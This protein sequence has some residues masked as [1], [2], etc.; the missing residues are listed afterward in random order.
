MRIAVV[1]TGAAIAIGAAAAA[2][3]APLQRAALEPSPLPAPLLGV[4]WNKRTATLARFDPRSLRPDRRRGV[5]IFA[6]CCAYAFSPD[7]SRLVL[8][9]SN[10][11]EP[12]GLNEQ[13]FHAR[14]QLVF[15]D[16]ERLRPLGAVALERGDRPRTIAWPR[17]DR[18]LVVAWRSGT[19]IVYAVDPV[20]RHVLARRTLRGSV[21]RARP[22]ARGLVVLLAPQFK[23]GPARLA[24]VDVDGNVRTAALR[25][26]RAGEQRPRGGSDQRLFARGAWPGLAVDDEARRAFVVPAGNRVAEVDLASLAVRYLELQPSTSVFARVANWLQPAAQAKTMLDGPTRVA[27]WLGDGRLAIAGVD[28]RAGME[29]GMP[30]QVG[31]PAGFKVVDTRTWRVETVERRAAAFARAG[32]GLLVYGDDWD[33]RTNAA[34]GM[35]VTAYGLDGRERFHVLGDAPVHWV[36]EVGGRAYAFDRGRYPHVIDIA[37]GRVLGRFNRELPYLLLPDATGF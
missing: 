22:T 7:R 23:V 35:G 36:L 2:P 26:I 28:N 9:G 30:Y 25:E 3:P 12:V 20:R 18:L 4:T 6:N 19:W 8:G 29:R 27:H 16:T 11:H 33:S 1:L 10:A 34:E 15:L 24:V 13:S 14:G 31:K 17:P 37:T 21:E 5:R 32:D